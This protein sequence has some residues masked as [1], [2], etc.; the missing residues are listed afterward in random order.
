[1]NR[2]I[3]DKDVHERWCHWMVIQG[4]TYGF[5]RVIGIKEFLETPSKQAVL[6]A[7]KDRSVAKLIVRR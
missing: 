2:T 3:F 6:N 4:C 1:M 7:L 5:D